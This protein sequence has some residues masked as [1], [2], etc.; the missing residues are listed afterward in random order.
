MKKTDTQETKKSRNFNEAWKQRVNRFQSNILF[1]IVGATIV[2]LIIFGVLAQITG[3]QRFS[4]A[5][6][7]EYSENALR[8]ARSSSLLIE[9][10]LLD[11]YLEEK[12]DNEDYLI[13]RYALDQYCDSMDARFIYVIRPSEDYSEIT[14]IVSAVQT[15]TGFSHYDIGYKR[16]TS[17]AEYE[18]K[19]RN[20]YEGK[21]DHE[22]VV[23]DDP[24]NASG[25][26]ITAMIPIIGD[27]GSVV[28]ILCV[29]RQMEALTV[30]RHQYMIYMFIVTAILVII[31]TFLYQIMLKSAIIK[32]LRCI[33]KE[34]ARFATKPEKAEH[35]LT[36]TIRMK[37]EIGLLAESVDKMESDTLDYIENLTNVTADRQRIGTELKVASD[38]QQGMLNTIPLR[39]PEFDI[40]AVMNP[41]KAVGGDFYDYLLI[42]DDHLCMMIADVSGKGI[43][44]A[45]FMAI[46]KVILTDGTMVSM[47]PAEILHIANERICAKNKLDMFVT[48]WL[49]ILE[50]STGK[51]VAANAGHEF[52]AVY[53]SGGSFE[54]LHDKHGFVLGGMS[55]MKYTEYEL[56]LGKGDSLFLYTDG[57]AEA[58][59]LD[60]QL[61]GTE[62]MIDAL[63]INPD[64][65]PEDILVTINDKVDEFVG[66]ADQFDDL[67][68]MCLKYFGPES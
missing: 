25:A 46:S 36:D 14:F 26:H 7:E 12:E 54:L 57:V 59:D 60:N 53:R 64:A 42:D 32:P 35:P 55:G 47:S 40:C 33:T 38:I 11:T 68:M 63:N 39:R 41:A 24:L 15:G 43:P 3:Y 45:L 5:F 16:E 18:E 10:D 1:N 49:G 13:V 31:V 37:N 27:G 48:V 30:G 52:P 61:F 20:L 4:E 34:T 62:R 21:S 50:I 58:T 67:T 28:G 44:A 56:Q 51:M 29:Q 8:I 17:S 6:T 9:P 66:E 19:Y 22:F 23:R 2:M 65:K